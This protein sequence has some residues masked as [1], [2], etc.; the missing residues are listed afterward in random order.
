MAV[1]YDKLWK[2]LIDKKL[3]KTQLCEQAKVT[4]NAMAKLGRN[5]DVRVEVLVKICKVLE[6]SIDDIM[7]IV[8]E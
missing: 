3:N 4:T 6:C 7:D 2:L 8:S 1:C 5:E